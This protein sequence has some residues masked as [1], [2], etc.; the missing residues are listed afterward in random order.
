MPTPRH[1]KPTA[2]SGRRISHSNR[3][4]ISGSK[5]PIAHISN[6]APSAHA[7][8]QASPRGEVQSVGKGSFAK[9]GLR[10]RTRKKAAFVAVCVLLALCAAIGAGSYVYFKTT[11]KNLGLESSNA[12]Q[13]LVG[14]TEGE[15][16]YVLCAANLAVPEW[17]VEAQDDTALMLVRV[18]EAARK[19]TFV[20]F[21]AQLQVPFSDGSSYPVGD[22]TEELGD[23][24]LISAIADFAGVSISHFVMI[25]AEGIA[26][27]TSMVGGV[28]IDIPAEVDDP[29]AGSVVIDA[30]AQH[31]D[32]DAALT[33]LRATNVSGGFEGAAENRVRF[34]LKLLEAA[35]GSSG[36]GIANAVSDASAY[37]QTDWSA[38][39]LISAAEALQPLSEVEV[40]QCSVPCTET[41]SVSDW[42]KLLSCNSAEWALMC[43][44]LRVGE[45]PSGAT[46]VS[47]AEALRGCTVE[48]RNG[49]S[50]NGAGSALSSKL[51]SLGYSIGEVGNTTDGI[52]YPDTLVIYTDSENESSASMVLSDISCGRLVNGGDFYTTSA[53]VL[54]VIG[55]DWVS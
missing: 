25:D 8:A 19:L 10:R 17:S 12:A 32:A 21:P 38:S 51:E 31:L 50:I 45:D 22:A 54:V 33:L 49:A 2:R 44:A 40:Y 34:T 7:R 11:D 41:T 18:D 35:T 37:I 42:S 46:V 9:E 15:A 6:V 14:V 29:H 1:R 53:D 52:I 48:I 47:D 24:G 16:Y 28:D 3:P 13:A 23:A 55:A 36:I 5:R 39:G 30:G 27:A 26:S 20:S 4:I 43:E